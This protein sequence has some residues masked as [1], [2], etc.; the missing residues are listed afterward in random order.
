MSD[1]SD[2]IGKGLQLLFT[3]I[4]AVILI[5]IEMA[6]DPTILEL[7]SNSIYPWVG[8]LIV[9]TLDLI[10]AFAIVNMISSLF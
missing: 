1:L 2:E 5:L 7:A 4:V 10:L 3:I 8:P 6:F 9:M